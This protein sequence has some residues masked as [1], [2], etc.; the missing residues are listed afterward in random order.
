MPTREIIGELLLGF[1]LG[2]VMAAG[3]LGIGI[4]TQFIFG[5]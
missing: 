1:L 2:F 4:L 3:V 5:R